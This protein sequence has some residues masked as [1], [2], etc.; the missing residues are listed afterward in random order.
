MTTFDSSEH[1]IVANLLLRVYE[2][3]DRII[4]R[5]GGLEGL[6]DGAMLHS[7]IARPFATF[8]GQDLY[9]TD[10]EKAA[11]LFHSLIKSHPFM[12][13]T[14]RT[15]FAATIYF[16]K[17]QGHPIPLNLPKDKIIRYCLELASENMRLAAGEDIK[18][19]TMAEI[20]AW[21]QVLLA[22]K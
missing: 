11:A 15:A 18:P 8:G 3:H 20:A 17:E 7:A 5:T 10:W 13:G 12:D 21:F 2:I 16:L 4:A 1:Q 9:S 19:K 22:G 6:R 14:K